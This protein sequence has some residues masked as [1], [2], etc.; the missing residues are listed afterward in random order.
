MTLPRL[1]DV[2]Q[3]AEILRCR[4]DWLRR[5]AAAGDVPSRKIGRTRLFAETDLEEYLERVRQGR[6]P[7][8]L[9]P[10]Q[11]AALNRRSA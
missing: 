6:D 10:Q 11:K 1:L 9:S 5:A 2:K 4:P 8:A 3:A 7:W